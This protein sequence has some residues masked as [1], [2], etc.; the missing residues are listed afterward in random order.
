M[1]LELRALHAEWEATE[2]VRFPPGKAGNLIRGAL[3]LALQKTCCLPEC[4][5]PESCPERFTCVY[6]RLFE[7]VASGR[8]PSGLADPPRPFVLRAAHLDGRHFKPGRLFGF[9]LHLF[10]LDPAPSEALRAAM[11]RLAEHGLGRE[12]GHAI[13]RGV[14]LRPVTLDLAPED[15]APARIRVRFVTPTEL[16]HAGRKVGV[17][18]FPIL[19]ARIRDRLS[20]LRSLYGPGPL[21]IDFRDLVRRAEAVRIVSCR[22]EQREVSRR[23]S[24]TGQTHLIGGFL[25]DVVYEGELGEF[26]PYLRAAWWT[27]VGRHTVWGNGLIEVSPEIS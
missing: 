10:D 5:E 15:N 24:R 25:G 20:T 12:K 26:L 19:L 4:R 9:D 21:P 8:L 2:P 14:S 17:P 11:S 6:A 22:L 16:K 3:G 1:T 13:C 7:P 23:S 18:E 27:G